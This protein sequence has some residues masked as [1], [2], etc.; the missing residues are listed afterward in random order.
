MS[1]ARP[2][3]RPDVQKV[4]TQPTVLSIQIRGL[5]TFPYRVCNPPPAVGKVR[6][7]GVTPVFNVQLEDV[8]NRKHLPPLGLKDFEE[9]LL[10]VEQC[11]ENLYFILWLREYTAKYNQW[12]LRSKSKPK[13][14]QGGYRVS[15]PAHT[16]PS[17]AMSYARAK[18][19]FFTPN[20]SYELALSSEV[21]L[22][23][24]KS[25]FGSPHPDPAVFTEVAAEVT[26]MLRES[27]RRFVQSAYP[28]VGTKR[29]LCGLIMGS[30]MALAGFVPPIAVNFA[31]GHSRWLR[32]LAIPGLW[33]GL[34]IL[35]ASFH[36]VC[37]MIYVFGDLRQ[38]RRFELERPPGG[39][40]CFA[41][42]DQADPVS[43]PQCSPRISGP[44][45]LMA[46]PC[47]TVA[48]PVQSFVRPPGHTTS[49]S[50]NATEPTATTGTT[51]PSS[52]ELSP[53]PSPAVSATFRTDESSVHGGHA[54]SDHGIYVSPPHYPA[55]SEAIGRM[56]NF[57][58]A[59]EPAILKPSLAKRPSTSNSSHQSHGTRNP[60]AGSSTGRPRAHSA[61]RS[62]HSMQGYKYPSDAPPLPQLKPHLTTAAFIH[63]Y[64]HSPPSSTIDLHDAGECARHLRDAAERSAYALGSATGN[65][66]DG[67]YAARAQP[68]SSFDFDA[69]PTVHR[70]QPSRQR[71]AS[72]NATK[73][74]EAPVITPTRTPFLYRLKQVA[75]GRHQ[76][77]RFNG[78]DGDI[79]A[80][81]RVLV[82]SMPPH[83]DGLNPHLKR[84]RR[85]S[86]SEKVSPFASSN[87]VDG[88]PEPLADTPEIPYL[89]TATSTRKTWRSRFRYV[90][91]V[92]AF[93][94]L[95]RVLNPLVTRAQ[96]EIVVRSF[97]ISGI[98]S[99][100]LVGGLVGIPVPH[101]G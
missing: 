94:P 73:K 25:N 75:L 95:T 20:S 93:G 26:K 7:C 16:S 15:W 51:A 70:D 89:S 72:G 44:F 98:V 35:V 37:M 42:R 8:L 34:T 91:K 41:H 19:T 97:V 86:T 68:I 23:F 67:F 60:T 84:H 2:H 58:Q 69:L 90:R 74:F 50:S 29:A 80:C 33:L 18:Q 31:E 85:A 27:L 81:S 49:W 71:V 56:Y 87:E 40:P 10:F 32:L 6:S 96:W 101:R 22:P 12:A 38:L 77:D 14:L 1:S 61:P 53:P 64:I 11:S 99:W 36:G 88:E 76:D 45:S 52:R 9:W 65:E 62:L 3:T 66:G 100:M 92:P 48:V 21:L 47:V 5:L 57:P 28:N 24:R 17:L 79:E 46:K 55:E 39:S 83:S 54:D 30:V 78:I 13:H 4:Q 63:P 43:P 59:L 82:S